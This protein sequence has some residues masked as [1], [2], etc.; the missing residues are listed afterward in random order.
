LKSLEVLV[1]GLAYILNLLQ[2]VPV[3]VRKAYQS[4]F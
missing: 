4:K 3:G 1:I 2:I